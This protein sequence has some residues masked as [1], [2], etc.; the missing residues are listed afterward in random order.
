MLMVNGQPRVGA[1]IKGKD[2]TVLEA[3]ADA[4]HK[5]DENPAWFRQLLTE[6]KRLM[7]H[8]ESLSGEQIDVKEV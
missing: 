8:M 4:I 7:G 5:V 6:M 1:V 3:E 2:S